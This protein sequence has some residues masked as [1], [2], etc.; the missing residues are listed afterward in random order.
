MGICR[1]HPIR[2]RGFVCYILRDVC[3]TCRKS[4][5]SSTCTFIEKGRSVKFSPFFCI[6]YLGSSEVFLFGLNGSNTIIYWFNSAETAVSRSYC[7][8]KVPFVLWWRN[9][10]CWE[11]VLEPNVDMEWFC[12]NSILFDNAI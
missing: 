12:E 9:M 2:H 4:T 1:S 11:Y 5:F 7:K 10:C 3:N 6:L 8:Y